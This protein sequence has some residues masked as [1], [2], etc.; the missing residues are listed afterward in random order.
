MLPFYQKKKYPYLVAFVSRLEYI[1]HDKTI[2][3]RFIGALMITV[4]LKTRAVLGFR[5][6]RVS[7][8]VMSCVRIG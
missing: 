8:F 2:T 1:T 7:R 3:Y 4:L 6:F 5:G